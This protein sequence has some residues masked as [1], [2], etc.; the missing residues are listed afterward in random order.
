M[1][2]SMQIKFEGQEHQIDA[3]VL[4]AVLAHYQTIVE[5][6]NKEISGGSKKINL[7]VNAIEKGSFI[8]DLSVV[9]NIMQ[10]IFCKDSIEYVASL[11]TVIVTV[12]S[13]YKKLKG[14]PIKDEK[15]RNDIS[16]EIKDSN[17]TSIY[18]KNVINIYNT[19][20][21]REAIS[22][23]IEAVD[24]DPSVDE[25]IYSNDT[26][27]TNFDRKDFKEYMYSDFDL[28][29]INEDK[30]EETDA[31]LTIVGLNFEPG[32]KWQ[33]IYN[34]FKISFIV[35]DDALMKEINEG[36]K[37]GKGDAIK[38]RLK[39]VKRFNPD[40][41]TYENKSYRIVEFY[42]LLPLTTHIQGELF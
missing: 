30:I 8:I 32:S 10:Q 14:K 22:K 2:K 19:P 3:N 41:N 21:V 7:K 42:K 11:S 20:V 9:E 36:A 25:L 27:K 28:E 26:T 38:V 4:I 40:Y 34:G 15:E 13:I 35:K 5:E 17:V 29:N 12:Y 24:A 1:K 6:S 16:T 18:V 23:S 31:I 39:I 33:F 37:F